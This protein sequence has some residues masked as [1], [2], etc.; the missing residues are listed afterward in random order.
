[1]KLLRD[2]IRY[3]RPKK[4]FRRAPNTVLNPYVLR[5]SDEQLRLLMLAGVAR[6][7]DDARLLLHRYNV[8]TAGEVIDRLPRR[9]KRTF[10]QRL[11]HLLRKMEGH[12]PGNPY[13]DR[14]DDMIYVRYRWKLRED[15]E[16]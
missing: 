7:P 13:G 8:K 11:I 14:R 6:D 10:K 5:E 2:L 16:R 15:S 1:M 4:R 9:K 3:F 12:Q